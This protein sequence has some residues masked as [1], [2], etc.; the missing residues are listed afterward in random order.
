MKAP[1][2]WRGIIGLI[3][4][5][6][7]SGM[8]IFAG[9]MK[10]LGFFPRDEMAKFGLGEQIYLI[11]AGEVISAVLLLV[12]RTSSLGVL[13]VSGFWGGT[14]ATHMAHSEAYLF[15]SGMLVLTWVGGYLRS[16]ATFSSFSVPPRLTQPQAEP[17][18]LATP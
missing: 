5:V 9:S 13:L 17:S 15:Q 6:L 12:P 16:P 4:H 7:V 1:M 14:I 8:M 3:L 11:G 10:L 2:N 18:N